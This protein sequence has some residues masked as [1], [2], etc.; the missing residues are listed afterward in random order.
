ME[1]FPAPLNISSWFW[2]NFVTSRKERISFCG[3]FSFVGENEFRTTCHNQKKVRVVK[4]TMIFKRLLVVTCKIV[5]RQLV[6]FKLSLGVYHSENDFPGLVTL[7][8][9]LKGGSKWKKFSKRS[10]ASKMI[11]VTCY[12]ENTLCMKNDFYTFHPE[13]CFWPL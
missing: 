9:I 5:S 2:S 7:R 3:R 8:M 10:I 12:T 1:F 6:T 4:K 11:L 13:N